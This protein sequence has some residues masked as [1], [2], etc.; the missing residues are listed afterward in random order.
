MPTLNEIENFLC[1]FKVH[2]QKHGM[3][4]FPRTQ[5]LKALLDLEMSAKQREQTIDALTTNDY[6]SGPKG[7]EMIEGNTYWEFGKSINGMEI[8]IKL[9]LGLKGTA[10][11][12]LAFCKAQDKIYYPLKDLA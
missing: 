7:F 10:V 6:C 11:F 12:C 9:S 4:V 8:Y 1:G 3:V 2:K 5:N